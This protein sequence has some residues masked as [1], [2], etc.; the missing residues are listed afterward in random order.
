MVITTVYFTL[1][2]QTALIPHLHLQRLWLPSA[3]YQPQHLRSRWVSCY[4]I[5]PDS[6]ETALSK[7]PKFDCCI[8][9][10][11]ACTE[12]YSCT[13]VIKKEWKLTDADLNQN[14]LRFI[15]YRALG[16]KEKK[17]FKLAEVMSCLFFPR[18]I[19]KS[20]QKKTT[21]RKYEIALSINEKLKVPKQTNN[22]ILFLEL[23]LYSQK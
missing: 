7:R 13:L 8:I 1:L 23:L 20:K 21:N 3:W 11:I 18:G 15:C 5:A 17:N 12:Y 10:K 2:F 22:F 9:K 6:S 4:G 14:Y 16:E 19:H